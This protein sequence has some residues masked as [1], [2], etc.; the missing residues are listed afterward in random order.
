M[1][2]W[3]ILAYFGGCV[4]GVILMALMVAAR[5]NDKEEVD[6]GHKME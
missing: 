2:G 4:T 3:I 5:D 1:V 6:D